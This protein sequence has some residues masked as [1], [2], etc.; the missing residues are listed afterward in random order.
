LTA[1][2]SLLI[3]KKILEG[4]FKTGYQTPAGC[5]GENLIMELPDSKII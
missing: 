5:Y 3:S 1:H 2:S 4:N